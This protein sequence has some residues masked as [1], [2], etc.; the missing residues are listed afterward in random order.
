M[1]IGEIERKNRIDCVGRALYIREKLSLLIDA[2]KSKRRK[3]PK[4]AIL[5]V[6]DNFASN[7][8]IKNKIKVA[9]KIGIDVDLKKFDDDITEFAL[10]EQIMSLNNNNDYCGM[11]VQL[12]LPK[13]INSVNV[14]SSIIP[15]KA[16]NFL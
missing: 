8:Y 11:I 1:H 13:Q 14:L 5:Q 9:D 3:L 7:I 15:N 6:G 2:K 10:I 16:S 12:P 4:M